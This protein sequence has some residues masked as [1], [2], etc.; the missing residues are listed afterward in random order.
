MAQLRRSLPRMP[1]S[2]RPCAWI[3]ASMTT[4]ADSSS[5]TSGLARN[6][7]ASAATCS[8]CRANRPTTRPGIARLCASRISIVIRPGS[9][10]PSWIHWSANRSTAISA[11]MHGYGPV[12]VPRYQPHTCWS[13]VKYLRPM[14]GMSS[15]T[16][17]AA[18]ASRPSPPGWPGRT[19][20]RRRGLTRQSV[21]WSSIRLISASARPGAAGR[22]RQKGPNRQ[23]AKGTPNPPCVCLWRRMPM[24][25]QLGPETDGCSM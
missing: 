14:P 8:A 16:A 10:V 5:Q 4:R 13:P 23:S 22:S 12:P 19:A 21:A 11:L 18:L 2:S 17:G 7:S 6:G 24:S 1:G 3:P 15:W 20:A 9:G 25:S